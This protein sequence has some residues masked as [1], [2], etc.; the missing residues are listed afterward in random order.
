MIFSAVS[1]KAVGILC[2]HPDVANM[3]ELPLVV[4]LAATMD[5]RSLAAVLCVEVPAHLTTIVV[6]LDV[7]RLLLVVVGLWAVLQSCQLS[8]QRSQ[9]VTRGPGVGGGPHIVG[10]VRGHAII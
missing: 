1:H 3:R 10:D 9:S 6:G 8:L 5:G 4:P 2:L 7:C